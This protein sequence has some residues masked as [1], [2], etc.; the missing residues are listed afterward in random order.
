MKQAVVAGLTAAIAMMTIAGAAAL[1]YHVF[2]AKPEAER[3]AWEEADKEA[4]LMIERDQKA[5]SDREQEEYRLRQEL[6]RDAF[7][8][9]SM[10]RES[11][12]KP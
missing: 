5:R 4:D 12:V 6:R 3:L 7:E 1:G 10:L 9:K 2:V 11:G 8:L